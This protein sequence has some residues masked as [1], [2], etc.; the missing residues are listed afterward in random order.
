[1]YRNTDCVQRKLVSSLTYTVRVHIHA[2]NNNPGIRVSIG[3]STSE[4][5]KITLTCFVT[6]RTAPLKKDLYTYYTIHARHTHTYTHILVMTF[7]VPRHRQDGRPSLTDSNSTQCSSTKSFFRIHSPDDGL[8]L[9][10]R[11]GKVRHGGG[12][13]HVSPTKRS[14][15]WDVAVPK[16]DASRPCTRVVGMCCSNSNGGRGETTAYA[17]VN[18]EDATTEGTVG[19]GPLGGGLRVKCADLG[20]EADVNTGEFVNIDAAGLKDRGGLEG[21][22]LRTEI[23]PIRSILIHLPRRLR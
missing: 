5:F 22:R 16:T 19:L 23:H 11:R 10:Q 15:G 3:F 14:Q 1:M 20:S 4:T 17:R 6:S 21:E 9:S 13:K 2:H 12:K 7:S 8:Q 18:V